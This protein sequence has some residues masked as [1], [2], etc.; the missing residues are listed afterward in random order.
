MASFRFSPPRALA[1][2]AALLALL[3]LGFFVAT[4]F[5]ADEEK[6]VLADVLS[7]ALSTPATEVSIGGIDGALSSDATIRDLKISDR[8]GVWLSVN[9]IRIVWRRLAL[10][11]RRLE[12]DKLDIDQMNVARK[13]IPAEARSGRGAALLPEL[14]LRVDIKQFSVARVDFGQP[15]LGVASSFSTGGNATLGPPAEG[16]QLFLDAQRLDRPAALNVRLNL[17]PDSQHLDLSVNLDE[18]AGGIL[19]HLANIPDRP[20]IKLSIIGSGALDAF[21]AKLAFD[22]GQ[23]VG[24]R[25][26]ASSIA[27]APAAAWPRSCRRGLRVAA[28]NGRPVLPERRGSRQCLLR[29]RQRHP[30]QGGTH[31]CC[32]APR[33]HGRSFA[34]RLPTS[35]FGQKCAERREANGSRTRDPAPWL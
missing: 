31:C 25:G 20:P 18:P 5:A 29:R 11:Q 24:A 10:L 15:V 19:S 12:I 33:C 21:N 8:D 28:A 9:R 14:P 32:G 30:I 17:V 16:L 7:R 6:G 34:R 35:N 1:L 27:R 26:D 13:P 3:G 4:S 2:A 22:A 23:G